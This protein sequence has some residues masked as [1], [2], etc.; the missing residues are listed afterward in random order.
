M[1]RAAPEDHL[2]RDARIRRSRHLNLAVIIG[3]VTTSRPTRIPGRI[4]FG[5]PL[6]NETVLFQPPQTVIPVTG[7]ISFRRYVRNPTRRGRYGLPNRTSTGILKKPNVTDRAGKLVA[8]RPS[9]S[10]NQNNLGRFSHA[11]TKRNDARV[12]TTSIG[13]ANL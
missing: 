7:T 4:I 12:Q 9:R 1:G 11:L 2:R 8:P 5:W 13:S 3:S 6:A 10:N